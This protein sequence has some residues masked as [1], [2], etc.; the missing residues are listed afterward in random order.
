MLCPKCMRTKIRWANRKAGIRSTSE[1][2]EPRQQRWQNTCDNITAWA[3]DNVNHTVRPICHNTTC[4]IHAQ[5]CAK[6]LQMGRFTNTIWK[7]WSQGALALGF[8]AQW[9]TSN[10]VVRSPIRWLQNESW[11]R[12]RYTMAAKKCCNCQQSGINVHTHFCLF[13]R[14]CCHV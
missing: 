7:Q 13:L 1:L 9:Q 10:A 11:S 14:L 5:H 2:A 12:K 6:S 4:A 8:Q 3:C